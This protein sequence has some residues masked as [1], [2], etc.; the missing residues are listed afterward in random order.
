MPG[1][2]RPSHSCRQCCTRNLELILSG[3]P[4]NGLG[5]GVATRMRPDGARRRFAGILRTTPIP[6]EGIAPMLS[7]A[8]DFWLLPATLF[9]DAF[10]PASKPVADFA[11]A[12]PLTTAAQRARRKRK[13]IRSKRGH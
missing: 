11:F 4:A 10:A 2:G 9:I 6:T 1:S 5:H 13:V 7:A 3:S 12:L 8:I